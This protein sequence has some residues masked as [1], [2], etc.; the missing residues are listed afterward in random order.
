MQHQ[1]KSNVSTLLLITV[2]VFF[3]KLFAQDIPSQDTL[4]N[5]VKT[6]QSDLKSLKKLKLSGL[7]QAQLQ[8]ADSN[9]IASFAGGNFNA[10]TDKRFSVR[11]GRLKATYTGNLS[12]FVVQIDVTEK[13]VGIKDA[14]LRFTYPKFKALH[15]TAGVFLRPFG[16]EVGYSSSSR[17]TPE[18]GRMSQTIF[19]GER[20]LG[21]M[22][23]FQMPK[24]SPLHFLTIDAGMFNGAGGTAV[25]FDY[26]KDFI[27]RIRA[28]R[29]T[30]SQKISYGLGFSYYDGGWR[31]GRKNEYTMGTDSAGV[32]SFVLDNDT[33]NFGQI[34]KRTYMGA[35]FQF[36]IDWVIGITTL[37]AEYITGQQPGSSSSTTSVSTQPTSDTYFRTFD[38]AYFYFI[39]DIWKTKHQLVV[40]YDWFDPNLDVAGNDIGKSISGGSYK[41]TGSGDLKYTTLG[42]GWN[43]KYDNNIKVSL[44]YDMVTNETSSNLS[45]WTKDRN[46]NVWTFRVQYKF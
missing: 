44:Y 28:D 32:S 25:D 15:L 17:E 22:L 16:F 12:L 7:I 26:Q 39:Q 34:A 21:M 38:G 35:D 14:Y 18:R 11:R 4:A 29:T 31:Q 43:Y 46:D 20:D 40:K 3:G 33:A 24:E 1:M 36:S 9:G 45:G 2:S 19:P 37:R 5:T 8:F 30:K 13:G 41:K 10:N 27:G 42:L 6:I 23:T